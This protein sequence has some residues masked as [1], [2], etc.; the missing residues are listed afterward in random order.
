MAEQNQSGILGH[1]RPNLINGHPSSGIHRNPTD[2]QPTLGR[3]ALEDEPV[4]GKIV[5]VANQLRPT[6]PRRDR[7]PN[8]LVQQHRSRITHNRLPRRST[9][10]NPPNRVTNLNRDLHPTLI[11]PP[12]QPPT[13]AGGDKLPKPVNGNPKRPTQRVT[14][15]IGHQLV[16]RYEPIAKASERVIDVQ[17]SGTVEQFHTATIPTPLT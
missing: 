17:S 6:R 16:V 14:I 11:P 10:Q 9:Q 12:N 1:S 4:R 5:T 7:S 8:Q 13:P 15:Q 3:H 2:P